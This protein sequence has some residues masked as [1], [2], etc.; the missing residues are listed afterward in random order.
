MIKCFIL[1]LLLFIVITI[2]F[3]S[4]ILII[5][6]SILPN[7]INKNLKFKLGLTGFMNTRLKDVDKISNSID[8]LFIGS[9]HA[10]RGFDTRYFNQKGFSSFNLGSSNQTPK[11]TELLLNEYLPK[12]KPKL[13]IIEVYPEIFELDGIESS[14]DI[15]SNS[16][17]ITLAIK[18]AIRQKSIISWNTLIYMI[19]YK[20]INK[21]FQEDTIFEGDHYIN[22]QGFVESSKS[23]Y[24]TKEP[25][26]NKTW[27]PR[28]DQIES[29]KKSINLL[30]ELNIKY[31]L[32]QAPLTKKLFES[33][34]NRYSID[35]TF[36]QYGKYIN[37]NEINLNLIDSIDFYDSNHL[38]QD[39]VIKFNSELVRFIKNAK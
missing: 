17:K 31:I 34:L 10:Y 22:N 20:F 11:Q 14:V 23:N 33:Y 18:E 35:S 6:G 13:V 9:S 4:I 25:I 7:S 16:N 12:I 3:Y 39:G 32:V 30:K 38:N 28:H 19:G 15:I 37:F 5:A 27:S 29:F 21:S 2:I 8:I 24:F 1:R 36:S 26:D